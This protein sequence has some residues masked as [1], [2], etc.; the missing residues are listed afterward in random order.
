M[1]TREYTQKHS[2]ECISKYHQ[3]FWIKHKWTVH[4]SWMGCTLQTL[5][6]GILG[7][8]TQR[9]LD[10]GLCIAFNTDISVD[11]VGLK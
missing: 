6:F 1:F 10:P 9:I 11:T 3:V 8:A 4:G 5:E 7:S 2:T